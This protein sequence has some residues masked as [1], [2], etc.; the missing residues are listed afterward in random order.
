MRLEVRGGEGKG[1]FA[2]G[3]DGQGRREGT[4]SWV[5]AEQRGRRRPPFLSGSGH[6]LES[7]R[8]RP[9]SRAASTIEE[10]GEG[11][12][13][14]ARGLRRRQLVGRGRLVGRETGRRVWRRNGAPRGR[15]G[16]G[17][18]R[19]GPGSAPTGPKRSS[20]AG[21]GRHRGGDATC[22]GVLCLRAKGPLPTAPT[23]SRNLWCDGVCGAR[24]RRMWSTKSRSSRICSRAT[25]PSPRSST[26]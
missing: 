6:R 26:S 7:S 9:A 1:G 15:E 4:A 16:A 12:Q 25:Q 10:G 2:G 17:A 22:A 11:A 21:H 19:R 24:R 8:R 20:R 14:F 13:R 23:S 18:S 3:W 5:C